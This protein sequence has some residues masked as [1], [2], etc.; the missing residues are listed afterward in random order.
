MFKKLL[1]IILSVLMLFSCLAP[2][3]LAETPDYDDVLQNILTDGVIKVPS[4]KPETFEQSYAYINWYLSRFW[5][6]D[7]EIYATGC[8]DQNFNKTTVELF[9][10]VN[11][12][13]ITSFVD[14]PVEFSE[15][16]PLYKQIVQ[17]YASRVEREKTFAVTD[18]ELINYWASGYSS[19]SAM[20]PAQNLANYSGEL[21]EFLNN[22]N[23]S[24]SFETATGMGWDELLDTAALGEGVFVYDGIAYAVKGPFGAR[25]QHVIY[26]DDSTANTKE[27]LMAAAQKRIDDYLGKDKVTLY[28][29]GDFEEIADEC[30][31]IDEWQDFDVSATQHYF[32]ASFG[33][34]E[35]MLLIVPDSA[36]MVTPTYKTSDMVT[37]VEIS[38]DSSQIPLDTRVDAK[39][40][41]SGEAYDKIIKIL[42]VEQDLTYDLKL[43]SDTLDDYVTKLTNGKF[44]VKIPITPELEG[45]TLVAYYVDTN[46]NVIP[47][48]VEVDQ[49]GVAQFETDHFSIYTLVEVP[50]EPEPEPEVA[51]VDTTNVFTDVVKDEWYKSY[52][53]Y[54]Y[55]HKLL[56]GISDKEFG[57]DEALTRGMFVTVLA[58]IDGV[59]TGAD[60]NKDA[61]EV[62]ADVK[63]GEYYS[64]AV[65]WAKENNIV[66][67]YED[68]TFKAT[69]TVSRQELCKMLVNYV[70][71]AK[72]T[73]KDD[74]EAIDFADA[75]KIGDWAKSA[76]T[77]CQK[78]GI[79]VG[80]ELNS[81]TY[82]GPQDTATRAQG[83]VILAKFHSE[84]VK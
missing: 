56:V 11:Y 22:A 14:L 19:V 36:K 35:Q 83:S 7:Y 60:A 66:A 17:D 59:D 16:E 53:D 62:F 67:G 15:G 38:S 84:Y 20:S 40:L 63:A 47:Y 31:Y 68:G 8:N 58:R 48:D 76:V 61:K 39:E 50:S 74:K 30:W 79:V 32:V 41:T 26:V 33:A 70:E 10:T 81:K 13:L 3:V 52:V 65:E 12:Q 71:F 45:K 51:V 28:Y 24:I 75:D 5:T 64:K 4:V 69:A 18:L 72:V 25:A 43:Y 57:V 46:D 77:A 23:L 37:A 2:C 27:A 49:N 44:L 80:Y 29:G 1:S 73:L 54:A 34:G 21:K 9:D 55:S 42:D 6:E 82:F 78:A